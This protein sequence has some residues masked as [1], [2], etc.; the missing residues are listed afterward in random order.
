M[1]GPV[2]NTNQ[3]DDKDK[4]TRINGDGGRFD[5]TLFTASGWNRDG[6]FAYNRSSLVSIA[7]RRNIITNYRSP[8]ARIAPGASTLLSLNFSHDEGTGY[9][10]TDIN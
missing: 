5:P 3:Y 8:A 1:R 2:T 7:T 4:D 9:M 6:T 10:S